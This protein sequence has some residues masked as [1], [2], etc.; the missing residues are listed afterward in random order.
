VQWAAHANAVFDVAWRCDERR[1]L[2]ASGDQT[3][4]VWDIET[5]Q[6]DTYSGHRSSIKAVSAHPTDP[7]PLRSARAP[8]PQCLCYISVSICVS[9]CVCVFVLV[10]ECVSLSLLGCGERYGD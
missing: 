8:S 2:T 10:G 3:V 7:R 9:V 5:K 1:L 4:R 6:H